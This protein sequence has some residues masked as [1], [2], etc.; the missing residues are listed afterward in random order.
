M[1]IFHEG[2]FK[3][4]S[5]PRS[6]SSPLSFFK[7]RGGY[8]TQSGSF[9]SDS[10]EEGIIPLSYT[11]I[12]SVERGSESDVA[13]ETDFI[14]GRNSGSGRVTP[15]DGSDNQ[16]HQNNNV[17]HTETT[18]SQSF[19]VNHHNNN[20]GN[21][22]GTETNEV[23]AQSSSNSS[24]GDSSRITRSV[25]S[26]S[27]RVRDRRLTNLLSRERP[28]SDTRENRRS[29]SS[30]QDYASPSFLQFEVVGQRTQ[31]SNGVM[32]SQEIP[33]ARNEGTHRASDNAGSEEYPRITRRISSSSSSSSSSDNGLSES[34]S[35]GSNLSEQEFI[36]TRDTEGI[37]S[38]R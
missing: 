13:Q 24:S 8:R 1:Q 7:R 36:V 32:S 12:A 35:S 27:A 17:S 15:G 38:L 37:Y 26:R 25:T 31:D 11:N 16:E 3:Y 20:R 14:H 9:S 30:V 29:R 28:G 10:S 2:S 21:A 23:M 6:L 22:I 34:D 4:R 19:H 18:F 33:A 5:R